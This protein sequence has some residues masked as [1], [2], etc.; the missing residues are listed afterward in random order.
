MACDITHTQKTT[1]YNSMGW[2]SF[3]THGILTDDCQAHETVKIERGGWK[4]ER[5][6]RNKYGEE[7]WGPKT[8]WHV[9]SKTWTWLKHITLK[10][11]T[12]KYGDPV[13][14]Y[15]L[16]CHSK[17]YD[18]CSSAEH[19]ICYVTCFYTMKADGDQ[20]QLDLCIFLSWFRQ[21]HFLSGKCNCFI[22]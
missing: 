8:N 19:K 21:H 10:R 14:I 6:R 15:S 18:F 20:G 9:E 17:T 12:R 2:K 3:Q 7:N 1:F 4:K 5:K 16:S 11:F 22:F 13:I